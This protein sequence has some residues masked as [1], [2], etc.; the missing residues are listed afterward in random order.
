MKKN[1]V[2]FTMLLSV[3]CLAVIIFSTVPL[4]ADEPQVWKPSQVCGTDNQIPLYSAPAAWKP[5]GIPVAGIDIDNDNDI[6]GTGFL[7]H[8][9]C[10][11]TAYHVVAG[12]N[13]ANIRIWFAYV[14]TTEPYNSGNCTAD[15]WEACSVKVV[16]PCSVAVIYIRDKSGGAPG[17]KYGY[18]TLN[19]REPIVAESVW[20]IG[21]PGGRCKEY[22]HDDY[23]TVKAVN[24]AACSGGTECSGSNCCSS[25]GADTEPASSGSPVFDSTGKVIGLHVGADGLI[26]CKNCFVPIA[27]FY[28]NLPKNCPCQGSAPNN[29]TLGYFAAR[30]NG[31]VTLEW[32]TASELDN[33]GFNVYRSTS[34]DGEYT[35]LNSELI[36]ATANA[37]EGAS[38][39]YTDKEVQPGLTYYYKLEDLSIEGISTFHGPVSAKVS[40]ILPSN[41]ALA[42]NYPN[43]FNASTMISY[44]LKTDSK[45]S[46]KVYNILG[47]EVVTLVDKYQT[48]GSYSVTWNGKDSKGNDLSTGVY[49]Y[50]LKAGDFSAK[51]KMTYLK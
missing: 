51:M 12:A 3:F 44:D 37:F 35:K 1:I 11:L 36:P 46:L 28:S 33:A 34:L 26:P 30:A 27:R 43:P 14:D 6:D 19:P 4:V 21:H 42:Q 49:F 15:K 23:A 20:V 31:F 13:I 17:G 10:L 22:S 50:I 7:Y 41:F 47:Q 29:V 9:H 24:D 48:A 32:T 18:V 45:V 8:T 38:Y 5:R 16:L 40:V 25:H 39:S 2:L